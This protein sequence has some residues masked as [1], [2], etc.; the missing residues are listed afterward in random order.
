[1]GFFRRPTSGALDDLSLQIANQLEEIRQRTLQQLTWALENRNVIDLSVNIEAPNVIVPQS[2]VEEGPILVV[3]LGKLSFKSGL[4][5]G[6]KERNKKLAQA[7][8]SS[9]DSRQLLSEDD[10]YD[11]YYI[12]LTRV[13][14]L[15]TGSNENWRAL[16]TDQK[17]VLQI[18]Q[19]FDVN[20]VLQLCMVS[21][22]TLT[23][24]KISGQLPSL[25]FYLSSK[26]CRYFFRIL[27]ALLDSLSQESADKAMALQQ[28]I[29]EEVTQQLEKLQQD[30][31][32][33]SPR[34][35]SKTKQELGAELKKQKMQLLVQKTMMQ[36]YFLIPDISL[37]LTQDD[38]EEQKMVTASVS[39]ISVTFEKRTFDM[40]VQVVLHNLAVEDFQQTW[41]APFKYLISSE[42][43]ASSDPLLHLGYMNVSKDS[44][45]YSGTRSTTSPEG[46]G[47]GD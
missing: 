27:R 12:D 13:R 44:P 9:S 39:G 14:A 35:A 23:K 42:L 36:L 17:N 32:A 6:E 30:P 5:G 10:F 21:S 45:E 38:G 8:L 3:D 43:S 41:G 34:L 2:F 40:T 20:L 22:E 33:V 1:V 7:D 37:T 15:I 47:L 31:A 18:I 46:M 4:T 25:Q 11:K 29:Q 26:R 24:L 28:K 16:K 19:D